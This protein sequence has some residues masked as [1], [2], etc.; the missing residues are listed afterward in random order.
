MKKDLEEVAS[1]VTGVAES[2]EKGK[3]IAK[4]DVVLELDPSIQEEPFLKAIKALSGKALE[5]VPV[6]AC[7]MDIE[8]VMEWI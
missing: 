4:E 3:A 7:K 2:S 1:K 5:G 6:F 8:L